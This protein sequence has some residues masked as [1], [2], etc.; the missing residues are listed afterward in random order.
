VSETGS[1]EVHIVT[2]RVCIELQAGQTPS[3]AL[4]RIAP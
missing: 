3:T 1:T 4:C 2:A